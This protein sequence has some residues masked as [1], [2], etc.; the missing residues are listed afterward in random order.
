VGQLLDQRRLWIRMRSSIIPP[1][2]GY[3]G[4]VRRPLTMVTSQ[5][6]EGTW[7]EISRQG[8]RLSG[9][10]VLVLV[11]PPEKVSEGPKRAFHETA[12][13]EEWAEA[14]L[15]WGRGHIPGNAPPLSDEAISRECIYSDRLDRQL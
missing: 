3:H 7:E 15:A 11:L 12:G 4:R 1:P 13:P 8:D 5:I 14:F 10:R 6:F 2:I 9:K